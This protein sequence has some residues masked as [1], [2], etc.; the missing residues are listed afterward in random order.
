MSAASGRFLFYN[1]FLLSSKGADL[2]YEILL[3][4]QS[5]V[6]GDTLCVLVNV[7]VEAA[8]PCEVLIV[9]A[10]CAVLIGV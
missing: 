10:L 9:A 5:V 3:Y 8:L 1:N 7:A 4:H 6:G 2:A